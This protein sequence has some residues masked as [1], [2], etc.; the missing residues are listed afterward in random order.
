MPFVPPTPEELSTVQKM[1]DALEEYGRE[2][3]IV[4]SSKITDV[5]ILR[6]LR[7]SK[8]DE[9]KG[10][11]QLI[12]HVHWRI[13][14]DV[15][16]IS[17][18][19]PRFQSQFDKKLSI[20]TGLDKE[21]RPTA[22]AFPHKHNASDRDLEEMRL[23]II[24]SIET[25]LSR[26]KPDEEQYVIVFDLGHFTMQCMDFEVVKLL[27]NILQVNYPDCLDK[28]LIVDSPFIFW[29]CWAVIKPW[30]DPVTSNKIAF[31]NRNQ[32][33]NFVDEE[34]IPNFEE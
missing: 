29:A 24:Y 22:F 18:Y 21:G 32:L 2:N 12:Q 8:G 19:L 30:L 26:S 16:N 15:D 4:I 1:R 20:L 13:D 7:G 11:N 10:M 33:P 17:N 3:N 14:N 28:L 9:A 5:G 23:F 6:F 27:I 25:N 31:I 34:N